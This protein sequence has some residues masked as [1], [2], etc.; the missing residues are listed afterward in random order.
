MTR[1]PD[2]TEPSASRPRLFKPTSGQPAPRLSAGPP[3]SCRTL[4]SLRHRCNGAAQMSTP[5][6]VSPFEE[7]SSEARKD[8]STLSWLGR[9]DEPCVAPLA[10]LE[11]PSCNVLGLQG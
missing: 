3:L 11:Y 10:D 5:A 1:S 8:S 2:S 4:G 7:R 9:N 6:I